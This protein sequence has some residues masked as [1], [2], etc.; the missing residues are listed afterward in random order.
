MYKLDKPYTLRQRTDFISKYEQELGLMLKELDNSLVALEPNE[1]IDDDGNIKI[2]NTYDKKSL[3]EIKDIKLKENN[4]IAKYIRRNTVFT[5]V[6]QNKL[7]EFN[8]SIETQL[9]LLTAHVLTSAGYIYGGF[10]TNNNIELNLTLD[11]TILIL[12][13]FVE[14]SNI[15]PIW[16]TYKQLI[17]QA[18]D[19]N[20]VENIIIDY[21]IN[22]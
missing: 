19:I 2:D 20:T 8:T 14:H 1:Y 4:I 5:V 9:D 12:T 21:K 7:C 17:S 6:V 15:G 10:I 13:K 18:K 11:D 22:V 3:E 16:N